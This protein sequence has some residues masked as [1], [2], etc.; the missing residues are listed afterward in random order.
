VR[1]VFRNFPLP[2]IHPNSELA[3]EAAEAAGAQGKFW[4]MHD[5]LYEHQRALGTDA[6]ARYA[7]EAGVD[8]PRWQSEVATHSYAPR[9]RE[10]FMSGVRS[11]VPGTPAF[12]VNGDAYEGAFDYASL[13][14]AIEEA[15]AREGRV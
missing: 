14:A 2:E 4:Q 6:L 13:E 8:L 12:F 7:A 5:E 9:I 10:D 3:A 1:F 11:G 15:L